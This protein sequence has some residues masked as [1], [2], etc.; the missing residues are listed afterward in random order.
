M[1]DR[2]RVAEIRV[3]IELLGGPEESVTLD[4]S[5]VLVDVNEDGSLDE[6]A[7]GE[8]EAALDEI[9]APYADADEEESDDA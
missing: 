3:T 1:R 9:L 8:I 5:V 4:S 2:E 6:A 7:L